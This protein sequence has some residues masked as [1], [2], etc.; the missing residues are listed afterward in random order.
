MIVAEK[1]VSVRVEISE[2]RPAL[3]PREFRS[4]TGWSVYKMERETD[5]P[6]ASLYRYLKDSDDPTYREPKPFVNRLFGEL[7][8]RCCRELPQAKRA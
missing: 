8:L 2:S 1:N 5:I 6:I 4:L 7:Y 3:T